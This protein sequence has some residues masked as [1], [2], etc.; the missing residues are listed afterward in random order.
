MDITTD[1]TPKARSDR[2]RLSKSI[3]P[4]S[5]KRVVYSIFDKK[6]EHD[7]LRSNTEQSQ[8]SESSQ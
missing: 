8:V 5:A 1:C 3:T 7:E 2:K 6:K 4:A